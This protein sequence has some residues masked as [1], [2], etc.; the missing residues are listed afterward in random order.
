MRRN[1]ASLMLILSLSFFGL[2]PAKAAD[3]TPPTNVSCAITLSGAQ[4]SASFTSTGSPLTYAIS[5]TEWYVS[6]LTPGASPTDIA[7]Y[8]P[9][10]FVKS[11]EPGVSIGAGVTVGAGVFISTGSIDLSYEALL[12]LTQNDPL[13]TVLISARTFNS[14]NEATPFFGQR[15][16][17]A[18]TEVKESM[19]AAKAKAAA[20]Q[21]A[22]VEKEKIAAAKASAAADQA[23]AEKISALALL[24][25]RA[26]EA[27]AAADK[28]AA[29]AKKITI[30]CVK[31]KLTKKVTAIKPICP[32][33]YKKK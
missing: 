5:K 23:A 13:G 3:V 1:F 31:G 33:G 12:V 20:D 17:L 27:K 2:V 10:I 7:S 9:P 11:S 26:L 30:T 25:K 29:S 15:S 16:Y 22:E 24:K 14:A 32:A 4:C 8:G 21:A 18:L 28:A 19:A 6:I